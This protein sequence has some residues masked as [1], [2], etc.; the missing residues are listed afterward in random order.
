[1][2]NNKKYIGMCSYSRLDNE[3]YLG[4]GTLIRNAIKRYGK[5]KFT[6][7][8]LEE[9][10]TKEDLLQAEIKWINYYDAT[11][12]LEFYNLHLGGCGGD[13]ALIKKIWSSRTINQKKEIG[14]K[15][16]KTRKERGSS[17]GKKNP[18]YGKH[19]SHLVQEVWN[20]RS[21]EYKKEIGDK[22]SKT[23]KELGLAKGSSN[24]MFGRSAVTEK[25]LKWYTNGIEN[26]YITEGTQPDN[27]IRGRTN[28]SG[29][30]GKRG[31]GKNEVI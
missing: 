28:V 14:D 19:T 21:E 26:K 18:M 22:V 10:I 31:K 9:C 17:T 6:R 7:E 30:V 3:R 5:S 1:M 11:N 15:I 29:N 16:S 2:I 23:R 25:N 27:F 4:S 24:P 13:S 20:K 8:I 12:N